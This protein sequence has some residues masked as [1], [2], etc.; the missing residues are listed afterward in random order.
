MGK[1]GF[2][3]I[4]LM[5]SMVILGLVLALS[6]SLILGNQKITAQSV[7]QNQMSEDAR[8]GLFRLTEMV[9]QASYIYPTG[10]KITLPGGTSVTTGAQVLAFLVPWE[11][12]YCTDGIAANVASYCAFVYRTEARA[13]YAAKLGAAASNNTGQVLVEYEYRWL[14]WPPNVPS[15]NWG[16]LTLASAGVV[17]DSVDAAITNLYNKVRLATNP[18]PVDSNL[19][20]DA[21]T[22]TSDPAALINSVEPVLGL[23]LTGGT[24]LSR[25]E[26]IF[27]RAIPRN[28]AAGTGGQ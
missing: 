11:S 7:T 21:S 17:A 28:A 24:K 14:S 18:S 25:S 16:T 3:L 26:V 10:Q 13:P 19:K 23:S 15:A 5:V 2:T 22:P 12:P 20:V 27:A 4:E 8:L 1:N 9:S 6:S